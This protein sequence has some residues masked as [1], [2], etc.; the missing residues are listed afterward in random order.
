M[1][2][3]L[4]AVVYVGVMAIGTYAWFGMLKGAPGFYRFIASFIA[5]GSLAE[6]VRKYLL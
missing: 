4:G 3:P 5:A 6:S 2:T 1:T